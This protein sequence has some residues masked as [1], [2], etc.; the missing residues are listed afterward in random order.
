MSKQPTVPDRAMIP[1]P[2]SASTR[3]ERRTG[4]VWNTIRLEQGSSFDAVA[5]FHVN[6]QNIK[7]ILVNGTDA[8]CPPP[9]HDCGKYSSAQGGA[10]PQH[11]NVT[12]FHEAINRMV[13]SL[14]TQ[15]CNA[16]A[17][18]RIIR[19]SVATHCPT[20][21]RFC[22]RKQIDLSEFD[23]QGTAIGLFV[24]GHA[25]TSGNVRCVGRSYLTAEMVAECVLD[26]LQRNP[27]RSM[28]RV[29]V[30][31]GL[32]QGGRMWQE[33]FASLGAADAVVCSPLWGRHCLMFAASTL[34]PSKRKALRSMFQGGSPLFVEG[35]VC[36]REELPA[37]VL[38]A[39]FSPAAA[40]LL[41]HQEALDARRGSTMY[42][43]VVVPQ[44]SEQCSPNAPLVAS[45]S[46]AREGERPLEIPTGCH[47]PPSRPSLCP[48][49]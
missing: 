12:Q 32:C 25:D 11:C 4:Y 13:T 14:S 42:V 40:P 7:W 1:F 20:L 49:G 8:Y 29:V 16:P 26:G 38:R 48:S 22:S 10:N 24:G 30:A 35:T 3:G 15:C 19:D 18:A 6:N 27:M 45:T 41:L 23:S 33:T 34:P 28:C 9:P 36:V 2:L 39:M 37:A 5:P 43:H 47:L 17:C 21:D 31:I 44:R 46:E